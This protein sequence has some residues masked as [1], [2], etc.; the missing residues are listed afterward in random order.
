ML[1][2]KMLFIFKRYKH[3]DNKTLAFKNYRFYQKHYLL[4]SHDLLNLLL[5]MN[6]IRITSIYI[7]LKT[8]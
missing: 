3:N 2:N 6:R 1:K 7:I 8:S 5:K 4:L